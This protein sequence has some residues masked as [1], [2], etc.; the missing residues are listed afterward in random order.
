M[1][2][3][4]RHGAM[5]ANAAASPP[6]PRTAPDARPKATPG[7][8]VSATPPGK[9]RPPAL[10]GGLDTELGCLF[11]ND[12]RAMVRRPWH[13]SQGGAPWDVEKALGW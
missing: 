9:A 7:A 5:Q 2:R 13:P 6:R 4:S 12:S 8:A 1:V 3:S 11:T 10:P